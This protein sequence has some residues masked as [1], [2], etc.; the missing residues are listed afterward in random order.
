MQKGSGRYFRNAKSAIKQGSYN[1]HTVDVVNTK[2]CSVEEF[3]ARYLEPGIPCVFEDL[4]ADWPAYEKWTKEYFQKDLGDTPI[5]YHVQDKHR[6]VSNLSS[7]FETTSLGDFI[8]R[9]EQGEQIQHFGYSHPLYD[10]VST[11]KKLLSDVLPETLERLFPDNRFLGLKR[12]N[13]G[14]WPFVPPYPIQMFIAGR[15]TRSFG[16]YDPDTSHTFHWCIWGEKH[17]KLFPYD[18]DNANSM[19]LLKDDDLSNEID[20]EKLEQFPELRDLQ[21]WATNLQPGQTLFIPTKTW[22]FFNYVETSMS[23]VCR[24]RSFGNLAGY[25]AFVN[26]VQSPLQT[27][28]NYSKLWRKI[29]FHKRG[30]TGNLLAVFEKQVLWCTAHVLKWVQNRTSH[31]P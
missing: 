11:H 30:I 2:T 6:L 3:R 8:E 10:F 13:P 17:V 24:A 5:Y 31:N 9:I 28:P 14:L 27:I 4:M 22:H 29:P 26:D 21:G 16:H 12:T 23:F 7:E 20:P 1:Y 19:W 15:D 18:A 25:N